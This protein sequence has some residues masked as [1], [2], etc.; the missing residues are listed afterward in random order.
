MG[1]NPINGGNGDGSTPGYVDQNLLDILLGG[2]ESGSPALSDFAAEQS[3]VCREPGT[4]GA[5][6]YSAESYSTYRPSV[7]P[8]TTSSQSTPAGAERYFTSSG[9]SSSAPTA[10]QWEGILG[11][12]VQDLGYVPHDGKTYLLD[13][14]PE[15]QLDGMNYEIS[16]IGRG[17]GVV[18]NIDEFQGYKV[19]DVIDTERGSTFRI[20]KDGNGYKIEITRIVPD[21]QATIDALASE[22]TRPCPPPTSA[23]E[24]ITLQ[25][26]QTIERPIGPEDVYSFKRIG[27]NYY[28]A[29][30]I[31]VEPGVLEPGP[32]YPLDTFG[33]GPDYD[34][35]VETGFRGQP[36][37]VIENYPKLTPA[38]EG[39]SVFSRPEPRGPVPAERG[40]YEPG[41]S[42]VSAADPSSDGISSEPLR[43]AGGPA[44]RL[45]EIPPDDF[46][47]IQTPESPQSTPSTPS[48][49]PAEQAQG[50]ESEMGYSAEAYE[51]YRPSVTPPL[52][53]CRDLGAIPRDGVVHL[54]DATTEFS[55]DGKS[56]SVVRYPDGYFLQESGPYDSLAASLNRHGVGDVMYTGN[57]HLL[58][59]VNDGGVLKVAVTRN[60]PAGS[61]SSE[62]MDWSDI[63]PQSETSQSR[64][65]SPEEQTRQDN[66]R[67]ARVDEYFTRRDQQ[68]EE[69]TAQRDIAEARAAGAEEIEVIGRRGPVPAE[70]QAVEPRSSGFFTA[71]P[72]SGESTSTQ[73]RMPANSP[74]N[75]STEVS[76]NEFFGTTEATESRTPVSVSET[77][78]TD[79]Q[80]RVAESNAPAPTFGDATRFGL[81]F[82]GAVTLVR[83]LYMALIL[84]GEREPNEVEST[85]MMIGTGVALEETMGRSVTWG[86]FGRLAQGFVEFLPAFFMTSLSNGRAAQS[87]G[88]TEGQGV[89]EVANIA[90]GAVVTGAGAE[91]AA[92]V[93]ATAARQAIVTEAAG[94]QAATP[95]AARVLTS[96]PA[97]GLTFSLF[98]D[99]GVALGTA[100]DTY[101]GQAL[102]LC[103]SDGTDCSISG[104]G[105][106][107]L[108]TVVD[109]VADAANEYVI[110]PVSA[111][112]GAATSYVSETAQNW[113]EYDAD[114]LGVREYTDAAGRQLEEWYEYDA[115]LVRSAGEAVSGAIS[116]VGEKANEGLQWAGNKVGQ[117]LEAANDAGIGLLDGAADFLTGG[118]YEYDPTWLDEI[119]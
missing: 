4:E 81:V 96:T 72:A 58:E 107:Q 75:R 84:G 90:S 91:A 87:A 34:V 73:C 44:C 6:G 40:A 93:S 30:M 105:A 112:V 41:R 57:G 109:P 15:F 10:A 103:T 100:G 106:E 70:R 117:G 114:L 7:T 26:G 110:A 38:E 116:Y 52:N 46:F 31:E 39:T 61:A 55:I 66:A 45:T 5:L 97:M 48:A 29:R 51:G 11:E 43:D 113:Y 86:S 13:V 98:Y 37:L 9:L 16:D 27:N 50:S 18:V 47:R 22:V 54:V 92:Q 111:G 79:V 33:F 25:D 17:A 1:S 21:F 74:A 80:A 115:A 69:R 108:H 8:T 53:E 88:S 76:A 28:A 78:S 49:S 82:G 64:R 2:D 14:G 3:P 118:E 104:W 42:G 99:R 94:V 23:E 119:F 12:G 71:D 24:R 85:T 63:N 56:Y 95:A 32:Y 59:L 67:R 60:A 101:W 20:I 68:I 89:V 102:G 35:G 83:D 19:G 62:G 36:E 65:L 77:V